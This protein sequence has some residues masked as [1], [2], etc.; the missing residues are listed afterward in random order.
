MFLLL[1]LFVYIV[2]MV[3]ESSLSEF[4]VKRTHIEQFLVIPDIQPIK[5][6]FTT[7][8]LIRCTYLIW[9]V[10]T[11]LCWARLWVD[12][13]FSQIEIYLVCA[14]RLFIPTLSVD[15]SE[16]VPLT[17]RTSALGSFHCTLF[18]R[19][20]CHKNNLNL[21]SI[22]YLSLSRYGG[23]RNLISELEPRFLRALK[24]STKLTMEAHQK[25]F[26]RRFFNS[27]PD[28]S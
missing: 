10:N 8:L 18:C 13:A 11:S 28:V 25:M 5:T 7:C 27:N 23:A 1:Y 20:T 24:A 16:G 2:D 12:V 21:F 22:R 26:L 9:D 4:Y 15:N 3:V 17:H 19:G 14:R 6:K